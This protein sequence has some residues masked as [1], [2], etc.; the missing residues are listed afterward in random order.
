VVVDS[1][2]ALVGRDGKTNVGTAT[3][4][5]V[6]PSAVGYGMMAPWVEQAIAMDEGSAEGE[7]GPISNDNKKLKQNATCKGYGIPQPVQ[8]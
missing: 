8:C 5:P 6:H 3:V 2:N 1:H 4:D 7:R